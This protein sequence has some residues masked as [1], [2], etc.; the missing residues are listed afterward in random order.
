MIT[1]VIG[2]AL[3]TGFMMQFSKTPQGNLRRKWNRIMESCKKENKLEETYELYEVKKTDYGFRGK[4]EIP[5]GLSLENFEKLKPVLETNL[6]CRLE[7]NPIKFTNTVLLKIIKKDFDNKEFTPGKLK[8]FEIFLGYDAAGAPVI[9]NMN[10]F[11]HV[12]IAGITG[13]GKSRLLFIILTNLIYSS[14]AGQIEI[15]LCSLAKKDLKKYKDCKQV[16]S[17]LENIKD[18]KKRYEE[19]DMELD[20]R[21]RILDEA[22]V[23]NIEEYN[24]IS[25]NKMKYIYLFADEFSF[26]QPDDSDT[27][28]EAKEKKAALAYLKSFIKRGRSYGLFVV[29]GIQ[30]T[31][32]EEMPTIIRRNAYTHVTFRQQDAIASRVII[33]TDDAIRLENREAIVSTDHFTYFR[34]PTITKEIIQEYIKPSLKET[35][36][37]TSNTT[38]E[39]SKF[40]SKELTPE[41]YQKLKANGFKPEKKENKVIDYSMNYGSHPRRKG[42]TKRVSAEG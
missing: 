8:P 18:I 38:Q 25:K 23:D 24:K 27:D 10:R 1:E 4:V 12:L 28:E 19:L 33:G 15:N 11:P 34:T 37:N 36:K 14:N 26:Y 9:V 30:V 41:E 22:G 35:P 32:H 31:T 3:C 13:S 7:I 17:Y 39:E 5:D 42:V 40:T 21:D 6:G 29:M 20:R 2:I 16:D